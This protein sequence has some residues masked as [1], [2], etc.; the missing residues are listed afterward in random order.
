M[1]DFK[2][3]DIKTLDFIIDE[4]LK[5]NYVT[6]DIL[7]QHGYIK[8]EN[9]NNVDDF[10][11]H[12]AQ[13]EFLRYLHIVDSYNICKCIK[14]ADGE[15]ITKNESTFQFKNNGRVQKVFDDKSKI[16]KKD[17]LEYEKAKIDLRLNKWFL[18]YK[19]LPHII[20]VITFLFTVYIYLDSK[21]ENKELEKKVNKLEMEINK[22]RHK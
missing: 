20:T 13:A 18:K 5:G 4:A 10:F 17:E 9:D 19:W 15:F 14:T 8:K 16:S 11:E 2:K 6:A 1:K 21:N 22:L 12:D 7:I 3:N